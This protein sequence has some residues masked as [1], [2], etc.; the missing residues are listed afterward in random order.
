VQGGDAIEKPQETYVKAEYSAS[1][2]SVRERS[3]QLLV[4]GRL[5]FGEE[6][7]LSLHSRQTRGMTRSVIFCPYIGKRDVV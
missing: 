2:G 5:V 4:R 7:P 1:R 3:I 6:G